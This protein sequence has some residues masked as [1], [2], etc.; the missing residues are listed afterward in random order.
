M[1]EPMKQS[2]VQ[3]S[4]FPCQGTSVNDAQNANSIGKLSTYLKTRGGLWRLLALFPDK[5][6]MEALRL[7]PS[8]ITKERKEVAL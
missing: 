8:V 3:P 2:S 6:V 7:A 1:K 4:L 5:S